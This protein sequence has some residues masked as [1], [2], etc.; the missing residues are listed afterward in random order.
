MGVRCCQDES[1]WFCSQF[2]ILVF[3]HFTEK[4]EYLYGAD[5]TVDHEE[6]VWERCSTKVSS[7]YFDS[8]D[9]TFYHERLA[10]S[11]GAQLLRVRWYGEQPQGVEHVF[12]EL[13]THHEPWV[14][15]KSVKERVSI[16][17]CYMPLLLKQNG[18]P[19]NIEYAETIADD[20]IPQMSNE[21]LAEAADLLVRVRDLIIRR[22]LRPCVRTCYTRVS[23]QSSKSNALRLTLDRDLKLCDERNAPPGSWCLPKD[24][25][26]TENSASVAAP[27]AIFEVK[28]AGRDMPDSMDKL[29]QNGAIIDAHKFSKFLTGV[30]VFHADSP[31][32]RVLPYWARVSTFRSLFESDQD[33]QTEDTSQATRDEFETKRLPPASRHAGFGVVWK[34]HLTSGRAGLQPCGPHSSR[35]VVRDIESGYRGPVIRRRPLK[36]SDKKKKKSLAPTKRSRIEVRRIVWFRV[37]IAQR[38]SSLGTA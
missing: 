28:L 22:D 15:D 13:K 7:I 1:E 20:S 6:D 25:V 19:W 3:S 9:L 38:N 34:D 12:V 37:Q 26:N 16:K 21:Q 4:S 18:S 8:P 27:C 11:E 31:T 2:Y 32:L 29:V 14:L 33:T 17:E 36:D 5:A 35:D 23:F 24:S 30:A 10:R